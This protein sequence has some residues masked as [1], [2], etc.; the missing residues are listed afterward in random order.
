MAAQAPRLRF[1]VISLFPEVFDHVAAAGVVGKAISAGTI[2]LRAHQLRDWAGGSIHTV[3]DQPYGGG[4]GMVMRPEPIYAAVE[5]IEADCG[6]LFK[7][8]LTPQGRRL[9]QATVQQLASQTSILLFCGRYEGVDE[10][11]RAI[12]DQ[13]V[14]IGDYVLSGGEPAALVIIDAVGR[15]VPGVVGRP[16]SLETESFAD[17]L[18]EYPQY[19]RPEVFRGMQVPSVLL[20]GNHAQIARWRRARSRER[21]RSR[22]P[23]LLAGESGDEE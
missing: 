14:S 5:Q 19:T 3:D 18:L 4:P 11:V 16:E 9:D 13:E 7:V 17:G 2:G 15:L 1:E 20:S 23:D 21:T 12:F 22:R 6:P 8:L 10:R